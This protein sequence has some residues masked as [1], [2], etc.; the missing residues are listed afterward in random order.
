MLDIGSPPP[1]WLP[2]KVLVTSARLPW[3]TIWRSAHQI[4]RHMAAH[5]ECVYL[6]PLVH[7]RRVFS[8]KDEIITFTMP[9]PTGLTVWRSPRWLP[10]QERW[11]N[12][13][14]TLRGFR[15]RRLRRWLDH[16]ELQPILYIFDSKYQ[17]RRR[18]FPSA[19]V[20]YH[21]Y[22][23]VL[24]QEG[25][26]E[27][28][29]SE[30]RLLETADLVIACSPEL[31]DSKRHLRSDI[32]VIPN[33]VDYGMFATPPITQSTLLQTLPRPRLG[34]VGAINRKLDI[35][36]L[37]EIAE[38]FPSGSVILVGPVGF[39][40]DQPSHPFQ[41]LVERSNVHVLPPVHPFMVPGL[42][43]E[44]DVGI[45]PYT[46]DSW[47]DVSFPLKLFEMLAVGIPTVSTPVPGAIALK[48]AVRLA[49]NREDWPA[50]VRGA[51]AGD[52]GMTAEARQAVARDHDW[53]IRARAIA[54]LLADTMSNRADR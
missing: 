27:L 19:P 49:T 10:T 34:Y 9:V 26:E 22:D 44:L 40:K 53:S 38:A 11:P 45:A 35:P 46:L 2:G 13:E 54:G 16:R 48:K 14:S 33:G 41:A 3:A 36:A 5:L 52:G 21:L 47:A 32:E 1:D 43:R 29:D 8:R 4:P 42:L 6:E 18:Y 7:A 50:T 28:R 20:V 24:R 15:M 12:I 39:S 25:G 30:R 31:A 37:H 17:Y 51:L 23:D